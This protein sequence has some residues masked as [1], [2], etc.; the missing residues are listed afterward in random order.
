[1]RLYSLTVCQ[2]QGLDCVLKVLVVLLV[3]TLV[4]ASAVALRVVLVALIPNPR[5]RGVSVG[6]NVQIGE[7][8]MR[9]SH[10]LRILLLTQQ[11]NAVLQQHAN[12]AALPVRVTRVLHVASHSVQQHCHGNC[13]WV[14]SL[15]VGDVGAE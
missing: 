5:T 6:R 15:V 4:R 11:L 10:D 12:G 3:A 14:L 8:E 7:H 1:M 2:C 9:G 13:E